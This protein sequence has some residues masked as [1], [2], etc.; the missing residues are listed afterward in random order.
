[1]STADKPYSAAC[2]RNREPILAHLLALFDDRRAVIEIGS[3]TGQHAVCFG[4]A[5]PHLTWQ[6][7]DRLENHDG[8]RAWLAEAGLGNVRAPLDLDVLLPWPA[9][10]A[11]AAFSAN[12]S[13][14]MPW[15]AVEAMF[16][17]LGER[18][19]AGAPFV[20][21]GPFNYAGQYTSQ[22]NA[23][24]DA[25]LKARDPAMGLRDMTAMRALAGRCGFVLEADHAMPANNRLLVWRRR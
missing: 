25:S 1:M 8:I 17:G 15:P 21:Y 5:L 16:A 14:I 7:T 3:G 19:P 6:T 12:T 13:H 23:D 2:E 18:L 22:S 10:S 20:L 24:F 11:D 9:F 4:A